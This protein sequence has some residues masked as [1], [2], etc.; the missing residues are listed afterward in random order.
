MFDP[1]HRWLGIPKEQ[2]PP[3]H[4]RLLGISPD[5]E[6]REVIEEAAIRQSTHLRTYQA[7]Q[8]AALCAKLL[9]EVAQARLTLVDPAKR[10]VYDSQLAAK[11]A[12]GSPPAQ[13]PAPKT[14][15]QME[16]TS[17]T[18]VKNPTRVQKPTAGSDTSVTPAK[19]L[20]HVDKADPKQP[21][22]RGKPT[23]RPATKRSWQTVAIL[24]AV[25]AVLIAGIG[26][27][28]LVMS[29]GSGKQGETDNGAGIAAAPKPT[30]AGSTRAVRP[31]GAATTVGDK[32]P[33]KDPPDKPPVKDP[34]DKPPVKDPPDKPPVKDPPDKP[35]VKDPPDKPPVKDPP[36]KPPVKDPPDKPP[37]KDPP[38]K[39]PVKDPPTET[40][41]IGEVRRFE[42]HGEMVHSVA[43]SPNGHFLVSGSRDRRALLWSVKSKKEI[44]RFDH[45]DAVISAVFTPDGRSVVTTCNDASVRIWDVRSGQEIQRLQGHTFYMRYA[46]ASPEGR[47]AVSVSGDKTARVW[48]LKTG[49]ELLKF[50]GHT[51][52]VLGVAL[53]PDGRQA[54]TGG[55]DRV[56]RLW[57][58]KSGKEVRRFE[59][60]ERAVLA[61]AVSPD[62]KYGL[63]GSD[64]N[65]ARLWDLT[66][67]KEMHRL[68]GHGG[69]AFA[70]AF[71]P[72]GRHLLTGSNDRVLRLWNAG[73]GKLV[74]EFKG[75][76]HIVHGVAFTPDGRFAVSC[77]GDRSVRLWQLPKAAVSEGPSPALA[78]LRAP[79]PD[80]DAASK[81]EASIKTLFKAEYART[82]RADVQ[83]LGA[84]LLQQGMETSDDATGRY[85]L[86]REA[87][88]AALRSGD[89]DLFLKA[90]DEL[91]ADYAVDA[92]ALK[93]EGFERLSK[94][95]S[96]PAEED[97]VLAETAAA[98][99]EEAVAAESYE[100]AARLLTLAAAVAT[101]AKW[102][103]F[104]GRA[105]AREKEVRS[106]AQEQQ[107]AAEAVAAMRNNPEEPGAN[108]ARGKYL[109][110]VRGNW[111]RGVPHLARGNDASL[112][113]A[114][115]KDVADPQKPEA[116]IEVGDGWA[117]LAGK[118][119]PLER[120]Y[121]RNRALEWYDRA[122][123]ELAGLKR[124]QLESKIKEL[125][126]SMEPPRPALP[127]ELATLAPGSFSPALRT[128]KARDELVLD[129]GGSA[130]TEAA[131]AQ[132]LLWIARQQKPE[133]HWVFT[134][135]D[136][137]IGMAGREVG[138]TGLA[139]LPFLGSGDTHRRGTHSRTITNALNWL[140]KKQNKT[141][142]SFSTDGY[143]HA[144]ATLAVCEAYALSKDNFLKPSAQMALDCIVKWQH[145]RGGWRYKP[146]EP[147]DTSVSAWMV[148]AL[149]T[150]E[151]AGL[152]VPKKTLTD[153]GK[154]L[155]AAAMQNGVLFRYMA[156]NDA[157]SQ[158]TTASG[159]LAREL[160]GTMPSEAAI[161]NLLKPE[162]LPKPQLKFLYY[163]YSAT[164][165][166]HHVGGRAWATWN[167]R[168][169]SLLLE[170]QEKTGDH[171]GT[172]APHGQ[173]HGEGG[174]RLMATALAVM[175]LEVY[176]RHLPLSARE[177]AP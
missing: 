122:L 133:G 44:R 104:A 13:A 100:P 113:A 10:Q 174:A 53:T 155:D 38:D 27:A 83:A 56:M 58:V 127:A 4:Y 167:S 71:S 161:A 55:H 152:K 11:A 45:P 160:L 87:R 141:D 103:V 7:G 1:Y 173:H 75:H 36:D 47:R 32:P 142:G 64:D 130:R 145:T 107:A 30:G 43:V 19:K 147:G 8:H 114:A 85:V 121:M 86:L 9:N 119:S 20:T 25:P 106:L 136:P 168:M 40:V 57:D 62:G 94:M 66:T 46:V 165:V 177:S 84:K 37:V 105:S 76:E 108:L 97:R 169:T 166:M 5:E 118:H 151:S 14:A 148:A 156:E 164:Q 67:G 162:N 26:A 157:H 89:V 16:A 134:G 79:L 159:L 131:V 22:A 77:G 78:T 21:P 81:A 93:I 172:W 82:K 101:K 140:L 39:P 42:G 31:T 111:D 95:T 90:T 49:R 65:T 69:H 51:D 123:P 163:Y 150:G 128:G 23:Y 80:A 54:V 138:A 35:P 52:G 50:E 18:P 139:L 99:A 70:V 92:W 110:L 170:T 175:T 137:Q 146:G 132:G 112:K 144:I 124:S 33:V 29:P 28:V 96:A 41:E 129:T 59:G 154:Y 72:D 115:E 158:A 125:H 24:A 3:T 135:Y 68:T 88:S 60:H 74:Q 149:K 143:D 171:K 98:A 116:Q 48:D 2:Q 109:C 117:E 176:Y 91:G 34:P 126:K 63:S 12:T 17:I 73:T 153:A 102:T 120:A 15:V 61:C 6:D